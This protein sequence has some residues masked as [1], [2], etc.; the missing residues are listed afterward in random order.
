MTNSTNTKA[1]DNTLTLLAA[2]AI[3]GI[4]AVMMVVYM[5]PRSKM[6]ASWTVVMIGAVG[7]FTVFSLYRDLV[8]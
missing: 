8:G 6:Y 4:I 1:L 3:I 5:I 2:K 7:I